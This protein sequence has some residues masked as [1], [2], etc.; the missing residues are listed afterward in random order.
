M[1]DPIE[2]R[3]EAEKP[4]TVDDPERQ[5][6]PVVVRGDDEPVATP[7]A[8]RALCLS[9]G[10]S[11]AM[12]FHA[13]AMLRLNQAGLLKDLT[14]VSSVSGGSIAASA[15]AVAWK[16]LE[17]GGQD[18]KVAQNLAALVVKPLQDLA[19]HRIDVLTYLIGT[20]LPGQTP[21]TRF[22]NVL[23]QH[24]LHGMTL[25]QL[26]PSPGAPLFV[27]NATNL[28]TGDLWKFTRDEMGDYRVGKVL[29]PQGVRVAIAVAASSAFPPAYSPLWFDLSG[30]QVVKATGKSAMEDDE[31]RARVP[32]ADG[33]AYDNLGMEAAWKSNHFVLVSDG[34]GESK[35]KPKPA[36]DPVRQVFHVMRVMDRQVRALRKRTLIAGYET[37]L[38]ST[39]LRDVLGDPDAGRGLR[40]SGRSSPARPSRRPCS[41]PS[42]RASRRCPC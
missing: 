9:G 32:L 22:A 18:G 16:D 27:F 14:C 4:V 30:F 13:G 21:A 10:G 19:R 23:D 7:K 2:E 6:A 28:A 40:R 31:F 29:S 39:S 35:P 8:G 33:G 41:R 17:W 15:L 42:R 36:L 25:D 26:Q 12:L 1:T 24:L 11:R 3:H 5:L 37:H 34:G 38:R 20:I